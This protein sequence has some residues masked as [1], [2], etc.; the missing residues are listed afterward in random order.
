MLSALLTQ[1]A[2]GVDVASALR[3]LVER[4][5]LGSTGIGEGVALP[6][7]RV[8][9]LK[10]A[11]GAFVTLEQEMDYDSLDRKPVRMAFALLVP[12][13]ANDEHLKLL[14]DLA[15]VFSNKTVRR[16]LLHARTADELY[17]TLR[18]SAP[19]P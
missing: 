10:Q 9:G 6:H 19:H 18:E 1:N 4:E 3:S 5:Q 8:P 11:V 17:S 13:S 12:E 14:R 16:Q 2:P 15:I 7:G